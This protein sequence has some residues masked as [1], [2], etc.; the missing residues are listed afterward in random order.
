MSNGNQIT[1]GGFK[2]NGRMITGWISTSDINAPYVELRPWG[3]T[4]KKSPSFKAWARG[5][6]GNLYHLG[7]LWPKETKRGG[8]PE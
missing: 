3:R 7:T 8:L 5:R 4:G 6:E 1:I 2:D